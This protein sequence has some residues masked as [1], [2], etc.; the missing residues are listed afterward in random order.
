MTTHAVMLLGCK[1][2]DYPDFLRSVFTLTNIRGALI[3]MPHKITT[4]GLLD[5]T[6]PTVRIAGSCNVVRPRTARTPGRVHTTT[7]RSSAI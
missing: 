5:E 3:T 4:V 2:A 1:A 7:R 6:T